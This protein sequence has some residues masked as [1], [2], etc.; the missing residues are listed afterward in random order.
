MATPSAAPLPRVFAAVDTPDVEAAKR[1]AAQIA[2]PDLGIK[3]GL[4][5]FGANGAAGVRAVS[6]AT[7]AP[8]F[9]DL[10]FHDIPNTV[11]GVVRTVVPLR[12]SIINVH[13]GGG[14]AMMRAAAD[15]AAEAAAKLGVP[16]PRVLAVTV[17]TSLD[18]SDLE[19]VGQC[20]PVAEQVVR[21]A[22]LAQQCGMDGVVCSAREIAPIRER[23]GDDFLLV[24]P[25]IR[26]AGGELG[27]QKRIMT[28]AEAMSAGATSL[29]VGR[30]ITKAEDP[31]DAARA[32]VEEAAATRV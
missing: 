30:P 31:A 27:D 1:L 21:L 9:L 4:E 14:P 29:V 17:L 15:A 26:P 2:L 5:F 3:L 11:A 13:A 20:T 24:V 18:E 25:G 28:P 23:C 16:R 19:A 32:I 8:I 22:A 6:S 7:S 12:P 10:K